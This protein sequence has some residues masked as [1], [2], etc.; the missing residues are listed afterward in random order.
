VEIEREAEESRHSEPALS[1]SLREV[2]IDASEDEATMPSLEITDS[3]LDPEASYL[4]QEETEAFTAAINKLA[5]GLRIAVVL[6][7]LGEL[8]IAD[9]ASCMGL[10]VGGVKARVFQ[11]R[12]KLRKNFGR[13]GAAAKRV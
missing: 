9:T 11:G 13:P 12:R 4:M 5:G 2:P 7:E 10:S 8:S 1:G 6:R 3:V